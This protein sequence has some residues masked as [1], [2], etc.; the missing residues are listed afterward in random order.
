MCA[1]ACV[2]L[3]GENRDFVVTE[4]ALWCSCMRFRCSHTKDEKTSRRRARVKTKTTKRVQ[5]KYQFVKCVLMGF[6]RFIHFCC[7]LNYLWINKPHFRG[8][9][10]SQAKTAK[11]PC[12]S[13]TLQVTGAF[14]SVYFMSGFDLIFEDILVRALMNRHWTKT[15][16]SSLEV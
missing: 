10:V 7:L 6:F 15:F 14:V 1:A 11:C 5:R 2:C 12:G 16:S 8:T 9:I 13:Q 3:P 4:C